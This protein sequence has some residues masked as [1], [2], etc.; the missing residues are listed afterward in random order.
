MSIFHPCNINHARLSELVVSPLLTTLWPLRKRN[1]SP[2]QLVVQDSLRALRRATTS[3]LCRRSRRRRRGTAGVRAA[4]PADP[5]TSSSIP[6]FAL[7]VRRPGGVA[8]NK[9]LRPVG[10]FG[11]PIAI[12]WPKGRPAERL[13]APT[14]RYD[15]LLARK[16]V[17]RPMG[18]A[19]ASG[20]RPAAASS[21]RAHL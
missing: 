2:G 1:L 19:A 13:L 9:T 4:R 17:L 20:L 3:Y 7:L 5:R 11:R 16:D 10:T 14:G 21:F 6:T 8:S 15:L 12:V 18:G